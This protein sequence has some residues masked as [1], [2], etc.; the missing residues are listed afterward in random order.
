MKTTQTIE[1]TQTDQEWAKEALRDVL[2]GCVLNIR[3]KSAGICTKYIK[4]M[5]N[6]ELISYGKM[7]E[8]FHTEM[9][10]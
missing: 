2:F 8:E 5:S 4:D 3:L 10:S 7:L 6:E 9:R 1:P